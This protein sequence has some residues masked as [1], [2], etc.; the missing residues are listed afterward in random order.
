M[1]KHLLEINFDELKF[2]LYEL[3]AVSEDATDQKIK[4]AYRKL[5][6][7]FHPDKNN[8]IDEEIY[9]HLTLANQILT[10]NNL[11]N[12]YD[13]WLKS[14]GQLETEPNHLE[15]KTNYQK[16][17]ENLDKLIPNEIG[18][19]K[20]TY[21]EKSDLLNKKHGFD[22]NLDQEST[23]DKYNI[24]KKELQINYDIE[25][26]DIKTKND[27]NNKFSTKKEVTENCQQIIKSDGKIL[28]FNQQ[29]LGNE[30][31]SIRNYD[32]LY[33]EDTVQGESFSSLDNAFL[34]QPK[35]KFEET[36]VEEKMN[37]YKQYSKDLSTL[38]SNQK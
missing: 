2:N 26:L 11:R 22:S 4:K 13:E 34:L 32:L 21:Q 33:S 29:E 38:N 14:Y 16:S 8:I 10:N 19:V 27:F 36:N 6:L 1:S 20:L 18:Q 15:L 12:K 25:R 35:I 23:M 3:L 31:I 24:K 5:M 9:N 7:K 37:E 30:Y 17:T 28:E